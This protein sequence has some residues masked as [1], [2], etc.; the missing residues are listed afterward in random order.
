[1]PVRS[2]QASGV[3]S[4]LSLPPSKCWQKSIAGAMQPGDGNPVSTV[5]APV[6]AS[7][8]ALDL[9]AFPAELVNPLQL[10]AI[11]QSRSPKRA[12][13]AAASGQ[14]DFVVLKPRSPKSWYTGRIPSTV[15]QLVSSKIEKAKLLLLGN[16][17]IVLLALNQETSNTSVDV[18]TSFQ[19]IVGSR[20]CIAAH[21]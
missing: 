7:H 14:T 12:P 18:E 19:D 9:E 5:F 13:G 1:M 8:P 11:L 10:I 2:N 16:L 20:T 3:F 15:L 4:T 6:N 21:G 17:L